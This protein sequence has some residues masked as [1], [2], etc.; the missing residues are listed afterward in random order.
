MYLCALSTASNVVAGLFSSF[1]VYQGL[2]FSRL[3]CE[4]RPIMFPSMLPTAVLVAAVL[5]PISHYAFWV[6]FEFDG[7][8][9]KYVPGILFLQGLSFMFLNYI[10][11]T[12]IESTLVFAAIQTTYL[13]TLFASISLYRLFFHPTRIYRGPFWARL[14]VWWK[15]K[16]FI[17]HNERGY[18]VFDELHQKYGDVIRIGWWTLQPTYH[19]LFCS[20]SHHLLQDH[21]TFQSILST[22]LPISMEWG[23]NAS[24]L[25]YLRWPS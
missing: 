9:Y 16:A 18:A 19:D 13:V 1:P 10:G 20:A 22:Q 24:G 11:L 3:S 15:I 14:W 2:L 25:H 23:L 7:I 4:F 6:R 12:M 5:G 21:D 17:D 8:L